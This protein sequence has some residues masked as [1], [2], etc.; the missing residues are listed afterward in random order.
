M[1]KAYC[2]GLMLALLSG[3]IT[4]ASPFV[5]GSFA[6][7]QQQHQPQPYVVIFWGQD[8]SYCMQELALIGEIQQVYPELQVITVATDNFLASEKV[9]TTMQQFG[10]AQ[11]NHWVFHS[12][13]PSRLYFDVHTRWRGELPFTYFF[14]PQQSGFKR[15]LI[16]RDELVAW[17]KQGLKQ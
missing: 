5:M 17:I 3:P 8:C 2:F 15:G 7:I 16:Q 1:I 4:A 13:T 14:Q 12:E 6:E 11:A 10:L 9:T